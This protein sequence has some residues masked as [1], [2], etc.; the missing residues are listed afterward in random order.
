MKNNGLVFLGFLII[1]LVNISKRSADHHASA[2]VV[3]PAEHAKAV[4]PAAP[5]AEM[6]MADAPADSAALSGPGRG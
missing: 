1:C 3:I 4:K 5:I 2:P 6:K